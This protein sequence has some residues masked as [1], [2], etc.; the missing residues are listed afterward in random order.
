MILKIQ[1][2]FK[3]YNEKVVLE[4]INLVFESGHKYGLLGINGS[5]KT[6]ILK[7]LA[8]YICLNKGFVY[9]DNT[10]IRKKM[11]F[12]QNA[13]IL[14]ENPSFLTSYSLFKNLELIKSMCKSPQNIDLN[15]WINLYDIEKFKY[16]KYKNLSLGTK[17]KMALIQAFM[18]Q[19]KVLLLDEPFNSLDSKSC[20][21]THDIINTFS[22]DCIVILTSHIKEDI[23]RLCDIKYRIVDG[24]IE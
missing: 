7:V 5:G 24:I 22:K 9:Q 19:P 4:N 11:N 8:G 3:E 6:L 18:D 13:G 21:I 14:I 15:Y 12:I 1:N 10:I 23:N 17:Q 20:D 2:G 16:T